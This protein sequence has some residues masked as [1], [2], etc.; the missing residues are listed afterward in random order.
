VVKVDARARDWTDAVALAAARVRDQ[1]IVHL[2]RLTLVQQ[3]AL[4][5]ARVPAPSSERRPILRRPHR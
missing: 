5:P 4:S 2:H 1:V 3:P